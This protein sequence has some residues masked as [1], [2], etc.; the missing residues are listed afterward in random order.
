M[1]KLHAIYQISSPMF[2]G[3]QEGIC[4]DTIR[5]SSFKGVLRFWWRA[6]NWSKCW[7]E[8]HKNQS[9]ALKLLHQ[10][11]GKLFGL[12]ADQGGQG[13][14]LLS[15]THDAKNAQTLSYK[16]VS[17]KYG[18]FL[19]YGM[20][21]NPRN[22]AQ[23]PREAI[24]PEQTFEVTLLAKPQATEQEIQSVQDAM[25]LMGLLGSLGA[26]ARKGF[27]SLTLQSVNNQPFIIQDL[28]DFQ[29]KLNQLLTA[30]PIQKVDLLPPFT[31][32][33]QHSKLI[34]KASSVIEVNNDYREFLS[35]H[36][37]DR[38]KKYFGQPRKH[39]DPNLYGSMKERRSSPLWIH[40]FQDSQQ[41]AH[42]L[43][44][45]LPAQW[46]A[47]KKTSIENYQLV[48]QWLNAN[49]HTPLSLG[50]SF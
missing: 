6:L 24:K 19:S 25:T 29:K 5:P 36:E 26:K 34:K 15:L 27:G 38:F 14:F 37:N 28:Q 35:A 23:P 33:S 13:L 45:F 16:E 39:P 3:N 31:A 4:A 46:K 50:G 21:G 48:N 47:N 30:Y 12:D 40:Q 18:S 9:E 7:V 8:K 1:K 32:F 43:V 44:L 22:Q 49:G 42:T 17:K 10:R 2:L 11:E 41:N 20:G